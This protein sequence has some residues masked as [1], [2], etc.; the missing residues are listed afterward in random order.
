ML[1]FLQK[2]TELVE[3]WKQPTYLYKRGINLLSL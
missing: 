2:N 3:T 1:E